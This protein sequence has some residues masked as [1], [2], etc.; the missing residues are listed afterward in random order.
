MHACFNKTSHHI[1]A[2]VYITCLFT[3]VHKN[4][5]SIVQPTLAP[6]LH[7]L[8]FPTLTTVWV[9]WPAVYLGWN[10][11]NEAWCEKT[12]GLFW[13]LWML[14]QTNLDASNSQPFETRR[15][16]GRL[17]FPLPRTRRGWR[18]YFSTSPGNSARRTPC[19]ACSWKGSNPW[20][21]AS[22]STAGRVGLAVGRP[23][24]Q[25]HAGARRKK[26]N[27]QITWI[28]R[29]LRAIV[30][31]RRRSNCDS[32]AK[33]RITPFKNEE[34]F[35]ETCRLPTGKVLLI[36]LTSFVF[37]PQRKPQRLPSNFAEFLLPTK[38]APH[39][40][41]PFT[42]H[43]FSWQTDAK[44][45]RQPTHREWPFH[46]MGAPRSWASELLGEH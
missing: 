26:P 2:I 3:S 14:Y 31:A 27:A 24:P 41:W 22:P 4:L 18:T 38:Q 5:W 44:N 35:A 32:C 11:E 29:T 6:V 25:W 36:K 37:A 19:P 17:V 33:N 30:A 28:G 45:D 16:E 23:V 1:Y 21:L 20:V 8:Q 9:I 13:S 39:Q 34:P 7:I 40:E 12:A 10:G 43:P 46:T 42:R 15:P